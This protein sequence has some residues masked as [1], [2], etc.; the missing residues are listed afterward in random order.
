[1]RPIRAL[2]FLFLVSLL[3]VGAATPSAQASLR[4]KQFPIPT[5][6]NSPQGIAAGPDG[7]L[8]FTE[9]FGNKIGRVTTGGTFTEF[10]V[11]TATSF[12]FG[13]A[14]G[15]DGAMWF[16]E[17]TGNKIGRIT[18]AG[19]ITQ[20]PIPTSGSCPEGIAAGPDGALWFTEYCANKIGRSAS[21]ASSHSPRG[22]RKT[23][24]LQASPQVPTGPC[25]SPRRVATRSGP[26]ISVERAVLVA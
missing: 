16:T 13:I 11:P 1:M 8:W 9:E 15:P 22:S 10:P 5:A 12:P 20:S 17:L 25:G 3:G 4:G 14:A 19:A 18:T 23:P 26:S 21:W 6:N 7:V 24:T 2:P